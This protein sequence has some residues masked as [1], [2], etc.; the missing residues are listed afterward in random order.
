MASTTTSQMNTR[1]RTCEEQKKFVDLF[2]VGK[3]VK[4]KNDPSARPRQNYDCSKAGTIESCCFENQTVTILL[5]GSR[6]SLTVASKNIV[7]L[8]KKK[9]KRKQ[10]QLQYEI[11]V[12]MEDDV[13]ADTDDLSTNTH[14]FSANTVD[15]S[16]NMVDSSANTAGSF[17]N[18]PMPIND[19]MISMAS[20]GL[21]SVAMLTQLGANAQA[22]Y[23]ELLLKVQEAQMKEK[24]NAHDLKMEHLKQETSRIKQQNLVE[25]KKMEERAKLAAAE[26]ASEAQLNKSLI[27][28]IKQRDKL[29]KSRVEKLKLAKATARTKAILGQATSGLSPSQSA[30][31]SSVASNVS[32]SNGSSDEDT[33]A[34]F[35]MW[36][37]KERGRYKQ[38]QL[39]RSKTTVRRQPQ[40]PVD[41]TKV[42]GYPYDPYN[43]D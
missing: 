19:T 18:T 4:L 33:D 27:Q 26:R 23:L 17:T 22:K 38:K 37:A 21:P 8:T 15:S 30:F 43:S 14:D 2:G 6:K 10:K 7:F 13:I 11:P 24:Q 34:S 40:P 20:V 42:P 12:N 29:E 35:R 28:S 3:I 41:L 25:R 32:I 16:A 5:Q 31:S 36:W 1:S 9:R 39:K